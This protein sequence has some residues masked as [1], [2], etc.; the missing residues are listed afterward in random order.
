MIAELRQ[1]KPGTHW[2]SM[3]VDGKAR[4][5]PAQTVMIEKGRFTRFEFTLPAQVTTVLDI[6]PLP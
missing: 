4:A 1:L 2:A 6:G 5:L 3:Y